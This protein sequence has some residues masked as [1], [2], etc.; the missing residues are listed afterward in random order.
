MRKLIIS[1]LSIILIMGTSAF[2]QEIITAKKD[3]TITGVT[4]TSKFEPVKKEIKTSELPQAVAATLSNLKSQGWVADEN[5]S[6][7]KGADGQVAFFTITLKNA[8]TKETKIANFDI[9]GKQL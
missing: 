2:A 8:T 7:V 4:K 9:V 1:A 5:V 3:S 6:A